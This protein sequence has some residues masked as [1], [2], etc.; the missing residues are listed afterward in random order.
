MRKLLLM[1][2]LI[3]LAVVPTAAQDDGQLVTIAE[4]VTAANN[5]EEP[6]FT[7]LMLALEAANPALLE[8]LADE[9][10]TVTVF[11]P[12]DEAFNMLLDTLELTA[13]DLLQQTEFLNGVLGYHIISVYYF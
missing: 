12:T 13:D 11:A 6:E 10:A 2:S 1:L 8:T 9:N 4:V 5:A 3:L 7:T